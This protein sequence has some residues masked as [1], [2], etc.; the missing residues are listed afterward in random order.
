MKAVIPAINTPD[1][2]RP[3]DAPILTVA[4]IRAMK[5]DCE[6]DE[7]LLAELPERL[8][9]KKQRFEAALLFVTEEQRTAIYAAE[10]AEGEKAEPLELT[11]PESRRFQTE[12]AGKPTWTGLIM[13]VLQSASEGLIHDQIMDEITKLHPPFDRHLDENSKRYYN[14]IS[15]LETRGEIVKHAARFYTPELMHNLIKDGEELP[16]DDVDTNQPKEYTSGW[17]IA[18]ALKGADDGMSPSE[19]RDALKDDEGVPP[20][21]MTSKSFLFNILKQLQMD[22]FVVKDEENKKYYHASK[23]VKPRGNGASMTHASGPA[24]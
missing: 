6:A 2:G 21:L 7:K 20:A 3:E 18:L 23:K 22:G 5:A 11:N 4:G 17:F 24:R 19:I 15:K 12:R 9:K 1:A 10:D 13:R 16:E 8:A 14:A